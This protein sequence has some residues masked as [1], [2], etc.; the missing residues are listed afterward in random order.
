MGLAEERFRIV[1]TALKD[2]VS[3]LGLARLVDAGVE[4]G[5]ASYPRVR[6]IARRGSSQRHIVGSGLRLH[7]WVFEIV[8][9]TLSADYKES[10]DEAVRIHWSI[11]DAILSDPSLGI[12]TF[13]VDA[14]PG[15][16]YELSQTRNSRGEFGHML[17]QTVSVRVEA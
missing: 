7:N 14:E 2:L 16:E 4:P 12:R 10:Y 13:F 9:E 6:I 5:R 11:Y 15:V 8:I 3:G 17:V 1:E